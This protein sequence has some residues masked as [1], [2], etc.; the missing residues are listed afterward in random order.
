VSSF[1]VGRAL[2]WITGHRG[3]YLAL[4]AHKATLMLDSYEQPLEYNP[5]LDPNRL[6]WLAPLP[7]AFILA[8]ASLR[9]F[10][11]RPRPMEVP[12][13]LLAASQTATLLLFF[14]SGRYR[15]PMM[16]ALIA[17]AGFGIVVLV[18]RWRTRGIA[19]PLVLA[20]LVA[21]GSLEGTP[22]TYPYLYAN[23]EAQ[24]IADRAA[25][26]VE[27]GRKPEAEALF[28][29]AIARD[30][31]TVRARVGLAHLLMDAGR[32]DEAESLLKE[33]ESFD[34]ESSVPPDDLGTIAF[35]RGRYDDAATAFLRAYDREPDDRRVAH[36]TLVACLKAGR[37]KEALAT[38]QK[39]RERGVPI[40]PEIERSLLVLRSK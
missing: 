33:A 7:F 23:A 5:Q 2:R 39:A 21:V 13:L 25:A 35:R 24:G 29:R 27:L 18:E 15:L 37:E 16:P 3:D 28:R 8:L 40:A 12:L 20:A 31:E 26:Y 22:L 19:M 30:P 14:V 38:W 34:P 9:L 4:L 11:G 36:N 17:M 32:L 10:G 6:R 1:W